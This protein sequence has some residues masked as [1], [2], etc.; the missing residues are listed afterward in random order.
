VLDAARARPEALT[1][2]SSGVGTLSHSIFLLVG[3]AAGVQL[4]HVP[5]TGGGPQQ[6]ALLAGQIDLAVQA[7]DELGGLVASGDMLPVAVASAQRHPGYPNVPTLRELG[8]DVVADN[9][10]GW[11]G[12]AGM[13]PEMVAYFHDRFRQAM[14]TPIWQRFA[15]RAGDGDGYANG[16]D[17]QRDMDRLLDSIRAALGRN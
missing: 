8:M 1:H 17:F 15:E 13:P 12:P 14:A 9:M 4:L 3:R 16:P 2:G 5:Y 10:K 7:S 6:Q 11:I